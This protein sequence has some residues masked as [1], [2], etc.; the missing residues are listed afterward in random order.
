M[1]AH[2]SK[3][4]VTIKCNVDSQD[5]LSSSAISQREHPQKRTMKIIFISKEIRN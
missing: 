4:H 2:T 1:H 3:R 5:F